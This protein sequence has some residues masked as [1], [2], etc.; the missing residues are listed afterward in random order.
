[1]IFE[2]ERPWGKWEEYINESNYRV[3]RIIVHSG[4]RLSLQKHMLRSEN[5]VIVQG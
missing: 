5:W 3:K 2:E 4:M 1:M